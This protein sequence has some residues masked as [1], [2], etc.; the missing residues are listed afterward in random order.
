MAVTKMQKMTLVTYRDEKEAAVKRLQGLQ[1]V[2]VRDF[3]QLLAERDIPF[4]RV[5]SNSADD[6][7]QY[8]KSQRALTILNQ[9]RSSLS[10]KEKLQTKR[11]TMTIE[12]VDQALDDP[13]HR[14]FIDSVIDT[15]HERHE[16]QAERQD[17]ENTLDE[18]RPWKVVDHSLRT[19]NHVPGLTVIYGT[20]KND[21]ERENY[22][23]LLS[24]DYYVEEVFATSNTIGVIAIYPDAAAKTWAQQADQAG[25]EALTID[26]D[27]DPKSRVEALEEY[28]K[29]LLK[30]DEARVEKL[31]RL[32][33]EI[34]AME[35]IS[36][37]YY[38]RWQRQKLDQLI[39]HNDYLIVLEGWAVSEE[40][41]LIKAE[42]AATLDETR[43]AVSFA[44]PTDREIDDNMVPVKLKNNVLVT[45]F[46]SIT[47]MYG[48]PTYKSLDPT[49]F[50]TPFYMVFWGMMS[51]DLGY[52]ACLFV[53]TLL[54]KH[55]MD[56]SA[57][58]KRMVNFGMLLSIPTMIVGVIYGSAFGV[59][60]PIQLID[61]MKDAMTLMAISIGIGGINILVGLILK[62]YL[63]LK[64]NDVES[65]YSDGFGWIVLLLSLIIFGAGSMLSLPAIATK[66]AGI[67]ALVAAVGMLIVPMIYQPKK[68]AAFAMGFYNLY[69]ITGYLGDFISYARLMALGISGGSI[70]LAFNMLVGQL[71]SVARFTVGILLMVI[72]HAFNMFLT[73]LS[74]YVHGL[75]LIFVEFFG[76]FYDGGGK[77]FA[78]I[79]ILEKYTHLERE[80]S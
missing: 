65:A 3:N 11:P 28:R 53:L 55:F 49:P 19:M 44:E 20:V 5:S 73:F 15:E 67:V 56:L 29:T 63:A 64:N 62:T 68:G 45:P 42:L 36:E 2:E 61:P 71:P 23:A 17:V 72:L 26:L 69:G 60:L 31:Q 13:S 7:Q 30:N 59:T 14:Q 34:P 66:I 77:P 40:V 32:S 74:A 25:F 27:D 24:D 39:F 41:E 51:G 33:Q 43:Y 79:A 16:E 80:K 38:N 22:R 8:Q 10:L 70:A 12:A 46:E 9:Y 47:A 48:Y 52:G 18:L 35:Q 78:P 76:K 4:V 1:N 21:E 54:A 75:R 57:S 58:A 37:A 6:E 50:V